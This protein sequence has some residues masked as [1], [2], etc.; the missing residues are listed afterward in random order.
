MERSEKVADLC[1]DMG[2]S[3]R[4]PLAEVEIARM[5]EM[6]AEVLAETPA[7]ASHLQD[8]VASMRTKALSNRIPLDALASEARA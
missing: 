6:A 1:W 2:W 7:L 4:L 3:Y 8:C 5:G